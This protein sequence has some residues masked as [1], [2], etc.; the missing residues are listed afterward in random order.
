MKKTVSEAKI[1][2]KIAKKISRLQMSILTADRALFKST[3]LQNV[4]TLRKRWQNSKKVKECEN[5]TKIM[6]VKYKVFSP[7]SVFS[8]FFCIS[9][10]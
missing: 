4:G 1:W 5:S 3:P 7:T 9:K 6:F 10:M 8:T 2:S